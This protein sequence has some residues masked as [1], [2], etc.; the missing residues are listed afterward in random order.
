MV[1]SSLYTSFPAQLQSFL[2]HYT[3][4]YSHISVPDMDN[5]LPHMADKESKY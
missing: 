2:V 3:P 4:P 5:N 1:L